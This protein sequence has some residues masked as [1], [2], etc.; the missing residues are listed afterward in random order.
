MNK[1]T[2]LQLFIKDDAKI[3]ALVKW[4][5]HNKN[6]YLKGNSEA[7]FMKGLVN[8]QVYIV[9]W[10]GLKSIVPDFPVAMFI[11]FVPVIVSVK[12]LLHWSIGKWWDKRKFYDREKDW[13]NQRDPVMKAISKT[14]L[15]GKGIN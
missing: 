9:Y 4:Y 11:C 12:I 1:L 15:D 13:Y 5:I 7:S 6:L 2:L 10:L 14:V 8:A 3:E